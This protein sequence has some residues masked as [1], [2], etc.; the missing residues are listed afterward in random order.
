MSEP[1]TFTL[2]HLQRTGRVPVAEITV[3]EGQP[4]SVRFL[5]PGKDPVT[6]QQFAEGIGSRSIGRLVTLSEGMAFIDAFREQ[7][8]TSTYWG[9]VEE[10]AES[11]QRWP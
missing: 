2:Y 9:I 7:L 4:G 3:A 8:M 10:P 1:R 11:M 5:N 6:E